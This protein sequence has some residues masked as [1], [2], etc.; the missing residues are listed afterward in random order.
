MPRP[1]N[2]TAQDASH[3]ADERLARS[4]ERDERHVVAEL[5]LAGRLAR[6]VRDLLRR[7][8]EHA[9]RSLRARRPQALGQRGEREQRR[10]LR[11][12]RVGVVGDET[13]RVRRARRR[14]REPAV[15]S[16]DGRVPLGIARARGDELELG[17]LQLLRLCEAGVGQPCDVRAPG[18]DLGELA[19]LQ[20]REASAGGADDPAVDRADAGRPPHHPKRPQHRP[21]VLHDG[22]VRARAAALDHDRVANREL[23]Q[24]RGDAGCRPG[25]DGERR[26]APELRDAHRP[27]VAAQH[28]QRHTEVGPG[29]RRFDVRRRAFD[30]GEDARVDRGADRARLEAVGPAQLMAGAHG[31]PTRARTRGD[32]LLER[33]VVDCERAAHGDRRAPGAGQP[34]ERRVE[35]AVRRWCRA[36]R[37]R[38]RAHVRPRARSSR[39]SSAFARSRSSCASAR[40]RRRPARRL[41]RAARSSPASSRR[42]RTRPVRGRLPA[43]RAGRR[44]PERCRSRRPR[45]LV[46][47]RH[48]GARTELEVLASI[49]TAFVNVPPT[50]IPMRSPPVMRLPPPRASAA[51]AAA[52]RTCSAAPVT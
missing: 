52:T 45:R 39:P 7:V 28:E 37:A 23:V 46:R 27:A 13:E 10:L 50:S 51:G 22:H 11:A 29:E 38:S 30:D 17:V 14:Q 49:A 36:P 12:L 21:A 20:P 32:R 2:V 35:V 33:R 18:A 34:F 4:T 40:P 42:P 47:R 6:G 26:P 43:A 5:V 48:R 44:A 9:P 24:G 8:L 25:A 15:R 31:Q 19:A 41:P 16:A 1:Q 3:L